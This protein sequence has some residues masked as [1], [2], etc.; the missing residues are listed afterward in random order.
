MTP[1]RTQNL[2]WRQIDGRAVIVQPARG[3][4]H[5]LNPTATLLWE[6]AD[7]KASLDEIARAMSENF[8]VEFA[9]ARADAREFYS[10][11]EGHGLIRWSA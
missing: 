9:E 4:V 6:R 1:I 7:G 2:P 11:L 5:D 8:E 3:R 10:A